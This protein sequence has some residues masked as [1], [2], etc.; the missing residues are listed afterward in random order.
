[1]AAVPDPPA[2]LELEIEVWPAGKQITRVYSIGPGRGPTT[3]NPTASSARFR[4]VYGASSAPVPTM[5]GGEAED[6]AIFESV[7]HD[8]SARS[9]KSVPFSRVAA[10]AICKVLPT[11]DLRLAAFHGYG[12]AKA[13]VKRTQ[14]IDT[15]PRSY[16]QTA[17]WGQTVYDHPHEQVDGIVWMSRQFDSQKALMLWSHRVAENELA[18]VGGTTRLL[19]AGEGFELVAAV[20]RRAGFVRIDRP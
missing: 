5:Y 14:L 7:L 1:V 6:A 13:K 3:F 16:A 11:R 18:P 15:P 17:K 19:A 10:R 9:R 12:L 20:S 8:L 2:G 4:P